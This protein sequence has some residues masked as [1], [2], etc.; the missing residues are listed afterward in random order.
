MSA[1]NYV[2]SAQSA[3][4]VSCS[5]VC[6]F[7]SSEAQNLLVAKHNTIELFQFA[8][9]E[10]LKLQDIVLQGSVCAMYALSD[11]ERMGHCLLVVTYP[12]HASIL[13]FDNGVVVTRQS[14]DLRDPS[15]K[16]LK[17]QSVFACDVYQRVAVLHIFIGHF[18]VIQFYPGKARIKEVYFTKAEDDLVLSVA[19]LGQDSCLKLAVLYEKETR[20]LVKVYD[21]PPE[22]SILM[23]E[24]DWN[25]YGSAGVPSKLVSFGG[26]LLVLTSMSAQLYLQDELVPAS[27]VH[28][29]LGA[30][31]AATQAD[32]LRVF[33]SNSQGS[34]FQLKNS[35]G[36][37]LDI[38]E[39]GQTSCATSIASLDHN[40]F[41]IGSKQGDSEVIRVSSSPEG[42]SY[43][44]SVQC[45]ANLGPILDM[46]HFKDAAR[47]VSSVITCSGAEADGSLRYVRKG[48]TVDIEAEV[49][50]G[51]AVQLWSL[52]ALNGFYDRLVVG[53][54]LETKVLR[55]TDDHL[56]AETTGDIDRSQATL[57]I[58]NCADSIVQ[59]TRESAAVFSV[60]DLALRKRWS[61][62]DFQAASFSLAKVG[63]S[64]CVLIADSSHLITI[65]IAEGSSKQ[66]DLKEH[67]GCVEVSQD[68]IA[69]SLWSDK[70]LHILTTA[71]LSQVWEAQ[72]DFS[73][74]P[75]SL[76][77]TTI[78][79]QALLLCGLGDGKLVV[80]N[81]NSKVKTALQ[82]GTQSLC[83]TALSISSRPYIFIA[84]E[85]PVILFSSQQRLVSTPVNI[86]SASCAVPFYFRDS[87]ESVVSGAPNCED[88]KGALHECIAVVSNEQ[89]Q[90]MTIEDVQK[91][92]IFQ[93]PVK[94]TVRRLALISEFVATVESSVNSAN[95]V[96]LYRQSDLSLVHSFVLDE[97]ERCDAM[98]EINSMLVISSTAI[99]IENPEGPASL[100]VLQITNDALQLVSQVRVET[101]IFCLKPLNTSFIV[102]GAVS[103]IV[104]YELAEG[105]LVKR[106]KYPFYFMLYCLDTFENLILAGDLLK[107]VTLFRWT[108]T[109]LQQVAK[110]L[111]ISKVTDVK[112]VNADFSYAVDQFG[113]LF[114]LRVEERR[115][116]IVGCICLHDQVNCLRG[117]GLS[118]QDKDLYPVCLFGTLSGCLGAVL[119]IPERLFYLLHELQALLGAR[120]AGV[121]GLKHESYRR[122]ETDTL[123]MEL[124]N[125]I[126]G[127]LVET[128][129]E[130]SP[131]DQ[132]ALCQQFSRPVEVEQLTNELEVLQ[133]HH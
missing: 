50:I 36:N 81:L 133:R 12:Y 22:P 128:F 124:N 91:L 92:S 68:F 4:A 94:H 15:M 132:E 7:T 21:L 130:M 131:A 23:R 30:I 11:A 16:E 93:V 108:G 67:V 44:E 106:G 119:A 41:Y 95:L 31:T 8:D 73:V 103:S 24:T 20:R 27:I 113:N 62:Q 125:F 71:S 126:D 65:D 102:G 26:R 2:V 72:L 39:V 112:L 107:S 101:Q 35:Q 82:V 74:V 110:D 48:I 120:C 118:P 49:P 99:S 114:C 77:L 28:K 96:N 18:K 53:Y 52:R 64:H 116:K 69:Y 3:T 46:V 109:G 13:S 32:L 17:S 66:A 57:S 70:S 115:L 63:P 129:L 19:V 97:D 40:Y 75:R 122:L 29:P 45:F 47:S 83:M 55:L 89:L 34:L 38:V 127:D 85:A 78:E 42:L 5:V 88:V 121:G 123:R 9:D 51:K 98:V 37:D 105:Q 117:G 104:M 14:I 90:L 86:S 25:F 80:F 84:C 43:L 1:F 58:G 33:I 79:D 61:P 56:K 100:K 10:L 6:S 87:P 76:L 59:I 54:L 111:H 60:D